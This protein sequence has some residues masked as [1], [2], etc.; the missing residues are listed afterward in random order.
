MFDDFS[1]RLRQII[2]NGSY[3]QEQAASLI[4]ISKFSFQNYL[5][6][7]VPQA[8]ILYKIAR[9]YNVTM[10]WLLTGNET[11]K[12]DQPLIFCDKEMLDIMNSVKK[13]ELEILVNFLKWN[14]TNKT[15][16][17]NQE[18]SSEISE[19]PISA[20]REDE[21][22]YI[23]YISNAAA[24]KPIEIIEY[25]RG[26]V[27]VD[28][29]H[30]RYNAFIIMAD[31]DSMVDAGIDN[32]DFVIVRPQPMVEN[33]EIALVNVDGEEGT[34]KRFYRK[35]GMCEL[36]SANP[37]YKPILYELSKVSVK[38]KIVDVI[39]KDIAVNT[40]KHSE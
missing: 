22:E 34:I 4:G 30:A 3:T 21:I 23:P 38:G 9:L 12:F 32:G 25:K 40:M 36:H 20:I 33:G 1:S 5:N 37:K 7:R 8:E 2:D 29:R 10:E 28:K 6:G 13:E 11:N 17:Y 19:P 31:G 26:A 15:E 27:P 18:I 14:R 24:G 35:N 39:K 16:L